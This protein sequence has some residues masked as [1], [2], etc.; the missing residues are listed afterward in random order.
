MALYNWWGAGW[1]K[2]SFARE[3]LGAD[4]YL[5]CPGPSLSK[6]VSDV[7]IHR[8]GAFS[9]AVNTAYPAV[10]PDVWVCIDVP[11]CYDRRVWWE[12][13]VKVCRGGHD[14][15]EMACEGFPV[16]WC[17]NVYFAQMQ[18]PDGDPLELFHARGHDIPFTWHRNTL[19][20]ALHVMVWMGARKIHFVGCDMG[21]EKDYHDERVLTKDQRESNLRLYETQVDFI[22]RMQV[23]LKDRLDLVSCTPESP[24]NT[25]MPY[26]SLPDALTES[27][28]RAPL[29][30]GV[31][32]PACEAPGPGQAASIAAPEWSEDIRYEESVMVGCIPDQEDLVPWWFENYEAHNDRP[33]VVADF[34][35]SP[36]CREFLSGH[37]AEI[38]DMTDIPI[39][40][41]LRKPFAIL[42]CPSKKILWLD[43]DTEI[44]DDVG[45]LYRFC[46][47]G[48]FGIST[49]LIINKEKP[50]RWFIHCPIDTTFYDTGNIS[51]EHGNPWVPRWAKVIADRPAGY[52]KGDHEPLSTLWKEN[53]FFPHIYP[54]TLHRY[55]YEGPNVPGL[56]VV[57]WCAARG[58]QIVRE[59]IRKKR[60]LHLPVDCGGTNR[61]AT[62]ATAM[63]HL[64]KE[65]PVIVEIGTIR[66]PLGKDGVQGDGH[67]TALWSWLASHRKG[68]L[69]SVDAS[70]QSLS[71][72]AGVLRE[73]KIP[74]DRTKLVLS[75]GIEFLRKFEQPIDLLYLDAWDLNGDPAHNENSAKMHLCAF[76]IAEQRMAEESLVLIDDV[77]NTHTY[78]GKG[79]FLIPYLIDKPDWEVVQEGYQFLFKKKTIHSIRTQRDISDYSYPSE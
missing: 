47:G 25:F 39:E 7:N 33:V 68:Q 59:M 52:W 21:G 46:E 58:K 14:Y 17:P 13:F 64:K 10:R 9:F 43:L 34:G 36:E 41:W 22:K 12:P 5:Y 6:T 74:V 76:Q 18:K 23:A 29:S 32:M 24:L 57:H 28:R 66:K 35:V 11:E 1:G 79:K 45:V 63:A 55:A 53:D 20:L 2:T 16:K 37:A 70:E 44:R 42:R 48:S 67:S 65:S 30:G 72:C 69:Y 49:D 60:G 56:V 19:V 27:Q 54:Q 4:A 31:I 61:R 62:M 78:E 75:D 3:D 77:I 51:V 50:A 73:T 8:P 40:G 38:I 15:E 26:R 71:C